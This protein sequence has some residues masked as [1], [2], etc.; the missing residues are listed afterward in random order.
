MNS[1]PSGA[2]TVRS[3]LFALDASQQPRPGIVFAWLSRQARVDGEAGR[4]ELRLQT[5]N[6]RRQKL[7]CYRSASGSPSPESRAP[8][9]SELP[10]VVGRRTRL[11]RLLRRSDLARTS[12][13]SLRRPLY[14]S[15]GL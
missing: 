13:R 2:T 10:G 4:R 5:L 9:T 11:R 1:E 6:A 7:N 15:R 12:R 14:A 8:A 3:G